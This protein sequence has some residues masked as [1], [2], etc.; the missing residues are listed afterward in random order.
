ME[1]TWRGTRHPALRSS[2]ALGQ[3]EIK[4]S[5]T[6]HAERKNV[7]LAQASP[8]KKESGPPPTRRQDT[9]KEAL[10]VVGR[11][12]TGVFGVGVH[13]LHAVEM[14]VDFEGRLE[15]AIGTG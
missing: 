3:Q 12:G 13:G 1:G 2:P 7:G 15:E 9:W 5:R 6:I 11:D 8:R 4:S 14:L 10:L